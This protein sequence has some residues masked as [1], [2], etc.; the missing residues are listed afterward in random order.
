MKSSLKAAIISG[1]VAGVIAGIVHTI[2]AN[3]AIS[4]GLFSLGWHP[5][6]PNAYVAN[7]SL[8]TIFGVICGIF[9]SK[10]NKAIPGKGI[11]KGTYYGLILLLLSWVQTGTFGLIYGIYLDVAG[12]IFIGFFKWISYGLVLGFFYEFLL[13]RYHPTKKEPRIKTYDLK[14][15]I[16]PGAIAGFADGVVAA[17]VNAIAFIS[18]FFG[19][20]AAGGALVLL[21]FDFWMS[22]SGSSILINTIWGIVIGMI[23]TQVYNLIPGK[24]IKKGLYYGLIIAV[25]SS[26]HTAAYYIGWGI[27][28]GGLWTFVVGFFS[29]AITLGI[30]LG[31]LYKK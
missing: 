25:I 21:R 11:L 1:L 7:I 13:N 27:I 10:A 22:Q 30:V 8:G 9:Y 12:H 14:G 5:I 3:I 28:I 31:A 18:G 24:G 19:P 20:P 16:L 6:I 4:I 29:T 23:F 26:F 15:G 17:I 2:F